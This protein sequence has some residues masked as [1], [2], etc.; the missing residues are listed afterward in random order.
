MT[1]E[2]TLQTTALTSQD[3]EYSATAN[4]VLWQEYLKSDM[5]YH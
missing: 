3:S 2:V 1:K 5:F 4:Y